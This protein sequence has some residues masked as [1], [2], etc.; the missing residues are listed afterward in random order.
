MSKVCTRWLPK[1][2]TPIQHM[3]RVQCCQELLQEIDANP[4]KF[5]DRIV[6]GDEFWIY[7]YDPLTQQQAK[8]WKRPEERTPTRFRQLARS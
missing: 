4:V 6:T 1:L 2:L 3:N 7:H 8:F 5:L